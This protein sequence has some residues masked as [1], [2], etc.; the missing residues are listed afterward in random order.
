MHSHRNVRDI[1]NLRTPIPTPPM[2]QATAS[3]MV[4]LSVA[5]VVS[6]AALIVKLGIAIAATTI[7]LRVTL[8]HPYRLELQAYAQQ[9]NVTQVPSISMIVPLILWWLLIKLSPLVAPWPLWGV[10]ATFVVVA[11]LTWLL[12]P[13]VDGTRRLAYA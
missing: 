9:R 4:A 1:R 2:V 11:A 5:V 12:F 8:A 13:H 10:G 7:A 3:V 6:G